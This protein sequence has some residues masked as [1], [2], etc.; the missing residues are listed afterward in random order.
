MDRDEIWAAL[1]ALAV[2]RSA[3]LAVEELHEG[4]CYIARDIRTARAASRARC[5]LLQCTALS[6]Q[7]SRAAAQIQSS[8]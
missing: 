3:R 4:T 5:C 8:Q 7:P 6:R 2:K 1:E